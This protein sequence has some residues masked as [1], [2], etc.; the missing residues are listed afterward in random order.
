MYPKLCATVE[1]NLISPPMRKRQSRTE[2]IVV[3][4]TPEEKAKIVRFAESKGQSESQIIREYIRRL[5]SVRQKGQLLA[6]PPAK[7]EIV[8]LPKNTPLQKAFEW[9]QAGY[10]VQ[11][12]KFKIPPS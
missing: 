1:Q 5:P 11:I 12:G 7:G 8:N 10:T 3:R 6:L 9:Q 2:R 4:I